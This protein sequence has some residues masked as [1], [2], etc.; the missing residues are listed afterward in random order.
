[1]QKRCERVFKNQE[2]WLSATSGVNLDRSEILWENS[3]PMH[4]NQHAHA[5]F[6]VGKRKTHY[7]SLFL[8][9][10]KASN[11]QSPLGCA[12]AVC[13]LLLSSIMRIPVFCRNS[14]I[15]MPILHPLPL[16][17]QFERYLSLRDIKSEA[18][19]IK[20]ELS[21]L[22]RVFDCFLNLQEG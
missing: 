6:A 14:H 3:I 7:A 9:S 12:G 2:Y 4:L 10:V 20:K 8:C 18:V 21:L 22:K 16:D 5:K 1:M 11:L 15:G 19:A 17:V 13:Q